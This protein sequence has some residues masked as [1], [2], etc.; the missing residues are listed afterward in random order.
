MN[1]SENKELNPEKL[2]QISGGG[3]DLIHVFTHDPDTC[4]HPDRYKTGA[5]R[6]DPRRIF[7]SQHQ[8]EYFCPKCKETFW[9]DE[10]P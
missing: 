6:E 3:V 10:E 9:V 5:Q 1:N 8:F 4:T 7:F 2:E